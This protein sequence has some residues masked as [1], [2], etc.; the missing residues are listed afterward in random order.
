MA[1]D[2]IPPPSPAGKPQGDWDKR[3]P[4][5]GPFS[6]SELL[7]TD[8][9]HEATLEHAAPSEPVGPSRYRSRFGFILGALVG[10]GIAAMVII[11]LVVTSDQPLREQAWSTWK[12]TSNDPDLAAIQIANHVAHEYRLNSGDQLVDVYAQRLE[13][14]GTPLNV[15]I[16][17]TGKG[18]GADIIDI[19]GSSLLFVL[20]G[21]GPR[22]SIDT[23]E[24]SEKRL[25]LVQREA[26]ELSLY[27]FKYVK[28][29]DNVVAFLP[30]SPP[31]DAQK[32]AD[33]VD[34]Q[35]SNL[36]RN[37]PSGTLKDGA[38][39]ISAAQGLP[40][41]AMLFLP[42]D[43]R[44]SLERPLTATFPDADPPRPSTIT[45]AEASVFAAFAQV[46]GFSAT[47]VPDQTGAG[48]LVLDRASSSAAAQKS[49]AAAL[50]A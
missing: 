36:G 43:V 42:G 46:H 2:L 47:V 13:L 20:K 11:A 38:A 39:V 7:R 6:E 34:R 17:S 24:A 1:G 37:Q 29:I 15:V 40:V 5:K 19:P 9:E 25:R 32:E 26:Y 23:E 16:R 4:T 27:A 22:G 3:E 49:L 48:F 35:N 33:S 21:L 12:P 18:E 8:A 10:V 28:G 44:A 50:K 14:D 30:P 31:S 41:P 45:D